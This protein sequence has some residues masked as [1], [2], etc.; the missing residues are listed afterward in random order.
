MIP[1]YPNTRTA[2]AGGL[3]LGMHV[4]TNGQVS[5]WGASLAGT[6]PPPSAR[7]RRPGCCPRSAS[8]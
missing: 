7:E 4:G 8:E 1:H 2:F 3:S 6:A 5:S